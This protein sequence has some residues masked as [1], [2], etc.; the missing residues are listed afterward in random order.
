M[1]AR[2]NSRGFTVAEILII[3]AVLVLLVSL[4]SFLY[5]Q[6]HNN[7]S[8]RSTIKSYAGT[9]LTI[10][11]DNSL[12]QPGV[13]NFSIAVSYSSAVTILNDIYSLK[14]LP[15]APYAYQCPIDDGVIYTFNFVNP[16]LNAMASATGCQFVTANN[17]SYQSTNKFWNDVS[18]ATHEPVDPDTNLQ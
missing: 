15:K 5:V 10:K 14:L 2:I 3:V 4:G 16:T 17:K 13:D 8:S 11:R 9:G 12:N 6:H 7:S 1:T 18:N